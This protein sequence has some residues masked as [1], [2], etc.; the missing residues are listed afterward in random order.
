MR[1]LSMKTTAISVFGISIALGM[2]Y[3]TAWGAETPQSLTDAAYKAMGMS[4]VKLAPAQVVTLITRGSMQAWDPG[5]SESVNTPMKPDW[6]TSTFSQFWDR[7]RGLYRIEWDRPRANGERRKYTEILTDEY[8]GHMGGYVM[9]IDVNGGQPARAVQANN[10]P[11]HTESGLRLAATLRELE[12]VNIVDEM[13]E[14]PDRLSDL[15]NQ[16]AAGKSYPAVQYRGDYGTFTV[17]FDPATHFPA[18]VRTRDFE[19]HDGDSDYDLTLSDWRAVG[20]AGVKMPFHQV[21]TVNGTKIFDTT[22]TQVTFNPQLAVDAFTVPA[23]LRGK[24][25]APAP[26]GKIPYQWIL[27][28]LGNGFYLD[29]DALYTDDGGSLKMTDVAPNVSFVSGG[30]HNALVVATNSYLVV[31]DAAGDD[32]MSQWVINEAAKKY[33]GKPFRYVVLTH[34]H[35]DHTGGI[36]AY[37]AQ[38]ATIVVGKGNGAFFRKALA[39]PHNL[40]PYPLKPFTPKVI[41]VDGKWS[42][43]DA[44]R[45][46][47]AYSL[48]TAHATGYIIPYIPD[49]KLAF[50][51]DLWNP[52][53]PIN[54]PANPAQVSIVR[55]VEKMGIQPERFAG[56][57]G[58]VGNYAD[59]V[60]AVQ[61]TQAAR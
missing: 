12:R 9:G 47:D 29:S 32:G 31:F 16:R 44:G 48:D 4:D 2:A 33:P 30:S 24:A 56:G 26:V 45:E 55:G 36:R 58:A 15:P 50:V 14:N 20:M 57:H 49:A 28:R 60:Q 7:S 46:I 41:E 37:A 40:D 52:G 22:L 23:A 1:P 8:D 61:R 51:T 27:R 35:I 3:A 19:V 6:G 34:H 21:I 59:L 10:M 13:H 38:G 43:N 18:V 53:A 5:E 39:A 25:A 11:I 42:I 54:G 17:L